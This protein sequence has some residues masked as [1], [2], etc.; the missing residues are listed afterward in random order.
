M[1]LT[2][3]EKVAKSAMQGFCASWNPNHDTPERLA[4]M[5]VEYAKALL[6]ACAEAEA[7]KEMIKCKVC[8]NPTMSMAEFCYGC[9][10]KATVKDSLTVGTVSKTETV[11]CPECHGKGTLDCGDDGVA[12]MECF[13]CSSV[14]SKP[15]TVKDNPWIE[16]DPKAPIP[17]TVSA[18]R[19]RDGG[20]RLSISENR[21]EGGGWFGSLWYHTE[22][23][24]EIHI[25]HF[26]P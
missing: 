12:D 13:H 26:K 25:T 8:G 14:V 21:E 16:H 20:E 5:S 1:K 23:N 18:V 7:P 19:F 17:E 22:S 2:K 3:L 10:Q 11:E 4:S 9:V 6:A 24:P 15:E